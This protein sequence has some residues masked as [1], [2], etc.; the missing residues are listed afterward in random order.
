MGRR[1]ALEHAALASVS[2]DLTAPGGG[3]GPELRLGR[4]CLSPR[5]LHHRQPRL[6]RPEQSMGGTVGHA[7]PG[8]AGRRAAACGRRGSRR[9]WGHAS[10]AR[11]DLQARGRPSCASRLRSQCCGPPHGVCCEENHGL[12]GTAGIVAGVCG[13]VSHRLYPQRWT[14][15]AAVLVPQKAVQVALL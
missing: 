11:G 15:F 13:A 7:A 9:A 3:G 2:P 14:R 4:P 10:P 8:P 6:S 5:L 12:R 1:L